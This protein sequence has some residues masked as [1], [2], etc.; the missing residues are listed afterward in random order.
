MPSAKGEGS[1]T[2][3]PVMPRE[4][5]AALSPK[6]G[7]V[8][9][10]GTLGGGGH[11]ALLCE[12]IGADG[13]LLG[14]DRDPEA[15][16]A[17]EERLAPYP[18]RKIFE[19][20]NFEE[21][22]EALSRHGLS[23]IDAGLLDLG[24]SSRQLDEPSRGFSYSEDGPLNMRMDGAD[25]EPT[26]YTVVNTYTEPD[27]AR[28]LYE[29]GEERWSRRIARRIVTERERAPI[30]TTGELVR[31]IRSAMPAA[32]LR[33]AQHPAKRSFQAIRIEVND[34][35]GGLARALGAWIDALNPG[36]RLGVITFHSL[37][38]RIVKE[39][40]REREDPCTCPKEM[41]VC[42]C[43]K[44]PDARR[45]TRKPILPDAAEVAKNPRARSAKLRVIEKL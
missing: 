10:D 8:C 34:E 32:A 35:L 45:V 43:G 4:V 13:V 37:E 39:A 11:A 16:T 3:T 27:L 2:H 41:P 36:G 38:D 12:A 25:G 15:I 44:V 6:E 22:G 33:E 17:A 40:F 7:S 24:V 42:V 28:V 9:A 5:L 21:I 30:R 31:I 29:Y 1:Y 14:I 18:C 20:R 19:N 23:G 26:A